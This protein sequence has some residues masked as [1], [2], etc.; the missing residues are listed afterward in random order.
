[1][2]P[3]RFLDEKKMVERGVKALHRELGPIEARRFL[4]VA[5]RKHEDSVMRHRKWQASLDR[6][7]F[8][9]QVM[10]AYKKTP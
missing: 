7:E 2:K 8:I 4:A 1:L 3:A 10:E 5:S 6:E 9:R